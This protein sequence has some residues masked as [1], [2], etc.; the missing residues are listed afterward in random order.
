V[1]VVFAVRW[2]NTPGNKTPKKSTRRIMSSFPAFEAWP[3]AANG[4]NEF[5]SLLPSDYEQRVRAVLNAT[6]G[7]LHVSKNRAVSET[8]A[9]AERLDAPPT[10]APASLQE[11]G[12]AAVA[13]SSRASADESGSSQQPHEV[14]VVEAAAQP[15][16]RTIA[17]LRKACTVAGIDPGGRKTVVLRRILAHTADG[18]GEGVSKDA[19]V[20]G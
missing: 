2:D 4:E 15:D 14:L 19:P 13:F 10:P 6:A 7:T 5:M 9:L 20:Q 17:E 12:D 11:H 1:G 8:P 3:Q 16:K 18:V